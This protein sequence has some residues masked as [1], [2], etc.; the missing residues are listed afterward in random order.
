MRTT[1]RTRRFAAGMALV[2]LPFTAACAEDEVE[3][4]PPAAVADNEDPEV[5]EETEESGQG[6]AAQGAIEDRVGETVSLEGEVAAIVDENAFTIG[7]DQI[8]ENPILVIS[9]LN[10]AV[11]EGDTVMVEGEVVEF[12]VPGIE[13]DLDLD[14]ID[15]EF[16]DFDGDPA[17]SATAVTQAAS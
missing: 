11:A 10:P 15:N 1:P 14:L 9:S 7:G 4:T 17:I 16:E 5:V 3:T 13:E 8:G 2:V 6:G 12:S